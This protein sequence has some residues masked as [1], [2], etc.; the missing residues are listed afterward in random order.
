M[1]LLYYFVERQRL[2]TEFEIKLTDEEADYVFQQMKNRLGF[3]QQLSFRGWQQAGCCRSYE[4]VV[5]HNPSVGLIAHEIAHARGKHR[6]NKSHA[7][8]TDHI[9]S[10]IMANLEKWKKNLADRKQLNAEK[11]I[12]KQVKLEIKVSHEQ[13]PQ[14]KVQKIEE[15][16][17]QIETNQKRLD[18][19]WK[20]Y[21]RRLIIWQKKA[22]NSEKQVLPQSEPFKFNLKH[23]T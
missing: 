20:K 18:G 4:I 23:M 8:K 22:E 19:L 16:L 3:T 12:D 21:H 5:S 17:K 7:R 15:K 10:V 6:H 13:T 9:A 14:F 11:V 1:T 2:N